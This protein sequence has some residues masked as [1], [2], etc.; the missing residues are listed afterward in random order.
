MHTIIQFGLLCQQYISLL[1]LL[2]LSKSARRLFRRTSQPSRE[3]RASKPLGEASEQRCNRP[4]SREQASPWAKRANSGKGGGIFCRRGVLFPRKPC[5]NASLRTGE[6][7]GFIALK[8]LENLKV[9]RCKFY[10]VPSR[11]R[12]CQKVAFHTPIILFSL[13]PKLYLHILLRLASYLQRIC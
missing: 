3:Q 9:T 7:S 2:F 5:H 8:W 6:S 10:R 4:V 13:C 11:L 1:N 12:F